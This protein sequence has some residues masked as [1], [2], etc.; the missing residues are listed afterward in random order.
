[1][2]AESINR[3]LT[4]ILAA[5]V[6][7]YSR[8]M[9]AD[10]EAT[11]RTL[12]AYRAIIFGLLEKHQGRLVDTAGD[13]V[14]ADFG[15]AVE[16][17]RCAI[18]IQ[19]EL[20]VRNAELPEDRRMLFR[21]GI[22]VGDVIVEGGDIFGDAVNVAARLESIARPGSVCISGST[23]EQVKNK[24][25]IGFT[26]IGPQTVKNIPHPVEAFQLSGAP[27]LTRRRERSPRRT[28]WLGLT[29]GLVIAV[30][31]VGTYAVWSGE[32]AAERAEAL[33]LNTEA[34]SKRVE[35]ARRRLEETQRQIAA[36]RQRAAEERKR[37]AAEE[38][39]R[40]AEAE[41]RRRAEE[42]AR[43]RAEEA[44]KRAEAEARRRAEEEARQRAE[45]ARKRAETEARRKAEE[46]ARQRA[47]EARKRAEA[48]A[49]RQ[50]AEEA[51]KR[52]EEARKRAEAE[53]RRKAAALA[54]RRA[55]AL[56]SQRAAARRRQQAPTAS[57]AGP[58][59]AAIPGVLKGPQARALLAGHTARFRRRHR[60]K[61]GYLVYRLGFLA[62]G[63]LKVGCSFH[64]DRN[65]VPGFP[66]SVD[67]K[68]VNWYVNGERVCWA[69]R[70]NVCFS[71][72]RRGGSYMLQPA[73]GNERAIL[74]GPFQIVR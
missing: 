40:R 6:V 44:R 73:P 72:A 23:F 52:G 54:K 19:E 64:P 21:I 47:E 58:Q 36:E 33:R 59:L 14:L 42:E 53:A 13:S 2:A 46:E 71:V 25:S 39:K 69:I 26:D 20:A 50:A 3:K 70:G 35:E 34:A 49:Q 67:G 12:T 11:H 10:E 22:N 48:E 60:F 74:R 45:E 56:A 1:M 18:S 8:L 28:A 41:A 24:L 4:T 30:A 38:T 15:S 32:R 31:G 7:G 66:C 16:A 29:V 51:Q 37:R 63:V 68:R 65:P 55:A 17:V 27:V 61:P 57:R 5:D 62:G 43:Q 9:A